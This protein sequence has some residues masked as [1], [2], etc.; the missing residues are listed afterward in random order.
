MSAVRRHRAAHRR[1][2]CFPLRVILDRNRGGSYLAS[3]LV[4]AGM[5][6]TFLFLTYFFQGTLH[7]SALK[8][9]F[10]FLPFSG[11]IIIGAGAGQ[12][13]PASRSGPR[14]LMVDRAGAGR[15]RARCGSRA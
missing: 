3:L 9:G 8:T 4:G 2:R 11:G 5:L 13:P 1:T 10:A 15:R 6:G 7:Y 14:A 12:P